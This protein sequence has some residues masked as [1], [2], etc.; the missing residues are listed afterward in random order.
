MGYRVRCP[1]VDLLNQ[2][3][4]DAVGFLGKPY[5]LYVVA[6]ATVVD[7]EALKWLADYETALDSVTGPYAAFLLFFNEALLFDYNSRNYRE[8]RYL[9]GYADLPKTGKKI[10]VDANLLRLR[11]CRS[12]TFRFCAPV[13]AARSCSSS[14][15]RRGA[16]SS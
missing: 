4:R 8:E 5:A 16:V 3:S 15:A 13:D 9:P 10:K 6:L 2:L 12:I 14:A 1:G 7:D 11:P